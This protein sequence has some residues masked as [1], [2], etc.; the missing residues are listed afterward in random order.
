MKCIVEVVK[1]IEFTTL[2]DYINIQKFSVWPLLFA[3]CVRMCDLNTIK[4]V[5]EF[6][7]RQMVSD[8]VMKKPLKN[9]E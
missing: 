7:L 4:G 2:W 1:L 8:D 6:I 5:W 9:T 3:P